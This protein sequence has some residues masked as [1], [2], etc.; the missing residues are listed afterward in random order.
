MS[1][2][3]EGGLQ[4]EGL[5]AGCEGCWLQAAV[6]GG[7]AAHEALAGSAS[8][9]F[10]PP[11]A[12]HSRSPGNPHQALPWTTGRMAPAHWAAPGC[13][14][15]PGSLPAVRCCAPLPRQCSVKSWRW[16]RWRL[17][18]HLTGAA[19]GATQDP[20]P[21]PHRCERLAQA[22]L[23]G[24]QSVLTQLPPQQHL[25]GALHQ[26]PECKKHPQCPAFHTTP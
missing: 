23:G 11:H 12:A 14:M 25:G 5:Q 3:C 18:S 8:W 4:P 6:R 10:P 7:P 20:P 15:W 24:C 1:T 26:P 2:E 13:C 16:R 21:V 17:G 19:G 9:A 22:L